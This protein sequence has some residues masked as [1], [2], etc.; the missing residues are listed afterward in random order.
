MA[1]PARPGR[2]LID[3]WSGIEP[4]AAVWWTLLPPRDV[5]QVTLQVPLSVFECKSAVFHLFATELDSATTTPTLSGCKRWF[6][7]ASE[8]ECTGRCILLGLMLVGIGAAWLML[9]ETSVPGIA[10]GDSGE[11]LAQACLGGVPHPP[12]YPLVRVIGQ[13][14]C[15]AARAQCHESSTH[16]VAA[17]VNRGFAAFS[18]VACG[19]VFYACA[20]IMTARLGLAA[21]VLGGAGFALAWTTSRVV[22]M[23]SGHIEVFALNT[24]FAAALVVLLLEFELARANRKPLLAAALAV[25]CGLGAANQHTIVFFVVPVAVWVAWRLRSEGRLSVAM[26][27]ILMAF[28]AAAAGLPYL[29][30]VWASGRDIRGQW[31]DLTSWDGFIRHVTRAEYGSLRLAARN[32]SADAWAATSSRLLAYGMH[33]AGIGPGGSTLSLRWAEV[34][35]FARCATERS[36]C[37][38]Y[39]LAGAIA[40]PVS[41]F[42]VLGLAACVLLPCRSGSHGSIRS[43]V[44]VVAAAWLGFTLGFHVLAN[45]DPTQPMAHGIL[46]R[47]W[48]QSDVQVMALA[49][50]GLGQAVAA[51][52]RCIAGGTSAASRPGHGSEEAAPQP[53]GEPPR[54]SRGL[55][56]TALPT[57]LAAL[58]LGAAAAHVPRTAPYADHGWGR[59]EPEAGAAMALADPLLWP[60]MPLEEPL[61]PQGGAP[62]SFALHTATLDALLPRGGAELSTLPDRLRVVLRRRQPLLGG[63][64]PSQ[65]LVAPQS[66]DVLPATRPLLS[67]AQAACSGAARPPA[68]PGMA[69]HRYA[70][71]LL[72]AL[73]RGALLL[74]HSDLGWNAARAAQVA[75]GLRQDVDVL[76]LQLVMYP[77]FHTRQS[78]L[79]P[80]VTVPRFDPRRASTELT[81]GAYMQ[82]LVWLIRANRERAAGGGGL[83]L[84]M[85][86]LDES[87]LGDA[88]RI[89]GWSAGSREALSVHAVPHGL[90][91]RVL[92]VS[93]RPMAALPTWMGLRAARWQGPAL[94]AGTA[95]AWRVSRGF[96]REQASRGGRPWGW[97]GRLGRAMRAAAWGWKGAAPTDRRGPQPQCVASGWLESAL[98]AAGQPS[99]WTHAVGVMARSGLYQLAVA[100]LSD[101]MESQ[102]VHTDLMLAGR[103]HP[104][105]GG[106]QAVWGTRR[107]TNGGAQWRSLMRPPR[108]MLHTTRF[109]GNAGGSTSGAVLLP[110][111]LHRLLPGGGVVAASR[112]EQQAGNFLAL[113]EASVVRAELWI[114]TRLLRSHAAAAAIERAPLNDPGAGAK[115]LALASARLVTALQGVQPGSPTYTW[116]FGT[117]A[118]GRKGQQWDAVVAGGGGQNE[119][120]QFATQG[121]A[122]EHAAAGADLA[123]YGAV[124][125]QD[126]QQAAFAGMRDLLFGRLI[127]ALDW[128]LV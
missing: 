101:A 34:A 41:L 114:A 71:A 122:A 86:A 64:D 44:A 90:T 46:E 42:A 20:V 28:G 8:L 9:I 104:T 37:D 48:M 62:C 67:R 31:G 112:A 6:C 13:V 68:E 85:A 80:N 54:P 47:F 121:L 15:A 14:L 70:M 33:T 29:S 117:G 97:P 2:T 75:A 59:H 55:L 107:G 81:S 96:C 18:S 105:S 11:L 30:L 51:I 39:S 60:G 7:M 91:W 17:F 53:L 127:E 126:N 95:L 27:V 73:P 123:W 92:L 57:A 118:S 43:A 3:V 113:S 108:M 50:S 120:K 109:P 32:G 88:N 82:S 61:L 115:N 110:E 74:T 78:R 19:L 25:V 119:S 12:G 4:V 63:V 66:P 125:P 22:W 128:R 93:G 45:V 21:G 56:A 5:V 116:L 87:V 40:R 102:Q 69:V 1:L 79:Y 35:A 24:M 76:S 89:G 26:V 84:E 23:Y 94:A 111:R 38:W 10:G 16:C 98:S 58:W 124:W 36:H 100:L 77:W 99:A 106:P 72:E 103:A 83:F 52:T 65:P 49:A